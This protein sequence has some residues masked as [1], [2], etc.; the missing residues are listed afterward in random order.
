MLLSKDSKTLIQGFK[1]RPTK[2]LYVS[3]ERLFNNIDQLTFYLNIQDKF[4]TIKVRFTNIQSF[5]V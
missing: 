4:E 2:L 1:C 5:F 3:D